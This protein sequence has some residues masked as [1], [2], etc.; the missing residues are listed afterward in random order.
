MGPVDPVYA[1]IAPGWLAGG[2]KAG[3]PVEGAPLGEGSSS[4]AVISLA[5]VR[6]HA[7]RFDPAFNITGGEDTE[8]FSR[9]LTTGARIVHSAGAVVREDMP[10]HRATVRWHWRRWRRTGQTNARIRLAAAP[11]TLSPQICFASGLGRIGAG[12]A[13]AVAG[14]LASPVTRRV[15][16]AP[17]ARV[18]ARGLGYLDA[19]RGRYIREYEAPER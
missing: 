5:P 3:G 9:Y 18:T 8:F 13:L 1:G 2:A 19:V 10:L 11:Q 12:M 14:V 15:S 16:W 7:L 4:N 17:G 6:A